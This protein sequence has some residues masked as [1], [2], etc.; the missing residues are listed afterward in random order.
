VPRSAPRPCTAP[1][2][3]NL[4]TTRGQSR[5]PEHRQTYQQTP[6]AKARKRIY[7]SRRWQG[8]RRSIL[9]ERPWCA[10]DG[11]IELASD[12]DHIVA[13]RDGG[14]PW[15]TANL[16]PLCTRHHRHKTRRETVGRRV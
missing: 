3:P 11:C 10:V 14:D 5:C 1:G 16:Q 15:D 8:L 9:R 2:C 4:V 13:L 12:V 6:E 7:A